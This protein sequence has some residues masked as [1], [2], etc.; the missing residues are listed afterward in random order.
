MARGVPSNGLWRG[1]ES[2]AAWVA[3]M[4]ATAPKCACGCGEALVVQPHHRAKGMPVFAHGHHARCWVHQG[5]HHPNWTPERE[6]VQG[7]RE[8]AYFIPSVKRDI[9]ERDGWSCR[10]CGAEEDLRFD[11]VTPIRAGGD[12]RPD[13]GQLLCGGCHTAKSRQERRARLAQGATP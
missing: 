13:N 12:G 9:G 4:Q 6:Q 7:G 2:L 8:G 3:R 10:A 1:Q 5:R 11:H